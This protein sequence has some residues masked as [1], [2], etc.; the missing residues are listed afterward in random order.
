MG[1][2]RE[3]RMKVE[4]QVRIAGIDASGRPLLQAVT[5]G[6]ISR[7]GAL[8][9]GVQGAFEPG[10]TVSL[11]YHSNKARFRVIWV[12]E[13]GTVRAG[14]VGV[15][16]IESAKCIWDAAILPPTTADTY[17]TPAAKERREHWRIPC[18]LGAELYVQGTET[19]VRVQVTN[20]SVGGCFLEMPTL[21]PDKARARIVI[22]SN[23]SKLSVQGIVVSRRPGFGVS[24]KFTEMTEEVRAQLQHFVQAHSLRRG[25]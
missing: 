23:D 9:D 22:W 24:I 14:Q 12:G 10:E 5:T 15:Q 11:S 4:L 13:P 7:Q 3:P 17:V 2:R 8:L 1:K 6:N 19:V 18:R 21:A 25:R 20:I 16:S